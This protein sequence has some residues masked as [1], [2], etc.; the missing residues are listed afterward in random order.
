MLDR[1]DLAQF[2]LQKVFILLNDLT[3]R[4]IFLN[5]ESFRCVE[6]VL[7]QFSHVDTLLFAVLPGQTRRSRQYRSFTFYFMQLIPVLLLLLLSDVCSSPAL[8]I[9]SGSLP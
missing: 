7:V 5:I 1:A 2:L 6:N 4:G 3:H 9:F 8:R